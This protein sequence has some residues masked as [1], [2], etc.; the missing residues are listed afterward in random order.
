[1]EVALEQQLHPILS[2]Q[3][4][5]LPAPYPGQARDAGV[6]RRREGEKNRVSQSGDP[7]AMYRLEGTGTGLAP[8]G[9][10]LRITVLAQNG[11]VNRARR[12][13][14]VHR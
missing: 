8:L 9:S 11:V 10:H 1:M 7:P 6:V 5:I 2:Q 13:Q 12:V 3:G 14:G 4:L